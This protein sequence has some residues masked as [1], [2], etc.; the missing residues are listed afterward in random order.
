MPVIDASVYVALVNTHEEHHSRSWLWFK[1]AQENAESIIAPTILLS[2]VAAALSRGLDDS[3]LAI[4]VITHLKRSGLV[5]LIP[6]TIS[7]AER[8]ATIAANHQIRGCDAI[9]VSTAE[10]FH[11]SLITLD[12]QQLDRASSVIQTLEP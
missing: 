12:Q 3:V 6:V 1:K 7:L 10:Q 8:G 9:Y 5:E 11:E 4:R 2:E